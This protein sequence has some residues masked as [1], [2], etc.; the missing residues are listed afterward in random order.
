MAGSIREHDGVEVYHAAFALI[1]QFLCYFLAELYMRTWSVIDTFGQF[2]SF[3]PTHLASKLS[4][5]KARI[6]VDH[7]RHGRHVSVA[8]VA[9]QIPSR[10][11]GDDAIRRLRGWRIAKVRLWF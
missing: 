4:R 9:K 8:K 2:D 6:D 5:A 10:Q 1:A 7:P 3:Y 11:V